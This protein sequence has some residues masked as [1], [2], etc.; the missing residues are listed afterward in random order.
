MNNKLDR[1]EKLV[2]SMIDEARLA[3]GLDTRI[4]D[5]GLD[6]LGL[7][8]LVMNIESEFDVVV[9]LDHFDD[10]ITLRALATALLD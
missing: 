1:F 2:R 6:S 7:L 3:D 4:A 9:E 10:R 5:A 8:D